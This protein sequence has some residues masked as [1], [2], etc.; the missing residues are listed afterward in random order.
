MKKTINW[1]LGLLATIA[2]VLCLYA[3]FLVVTAAGN[4]ANQKKGMTILK[5]AAM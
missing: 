4:D 1:L 3:G 5:Q 2:L